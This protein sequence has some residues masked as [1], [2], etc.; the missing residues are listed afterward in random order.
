MIE[1]KL[2]DLKTKVLR[3][4]NINDAMREELVNDIFEIEKLASNTESVDTYCFRRTNEHDFIYN[5]MLIF[6]SQ[7]YLLPL[8]KLKH[9]IMNIGQS[10]R[11]LR[12]NELMN[13]EEFASSVGITQ[14][15][16]SLIEKGHKK[17]SLEVLQQMAD[18]LNTPLSVLFWFGIEREDVD[19]KKQY[20]YDTLK[21]SIDNLIK[22]VF[23]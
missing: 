20:A 6:L 1:K 11:T 5:V 19:E 14:S 17:P 12:K 15:Y 10:I 2:Y 9:K 7:K 16:L 4:E 22:E 8:V 23:S 18:I 21:P 13:Q 3:T